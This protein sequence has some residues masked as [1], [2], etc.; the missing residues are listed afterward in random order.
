MD[1]AARLKIILDELRLRGVQKR[2]SFLDPSFPAQ[3]N[4]AIDQ[5][6]FKAIQCTRRAGKSTGEARELLETMTTTAG[7]KSLY[8]ALSLDSAKGIIWDELMNQLDEKKISNNPDKNRGIITLSNKSVIKLFGLDASYKEKRKV[9][10]Q[11]YKRVKIDEAGSITQDL[12]NICYQFIAPSLIDVN[13]TLTLLGTAENIPNTFFEKVTSGKEAG[14]SVHKWTTLDNPYMKD[15]WQAHIDDIRLNRPNFLLTSEYRTHYL[16]EWCADDTLLIIRI[17]ENTVIKP[18]EIRNPTY[19]LGVDIGF[20][21]A[22]AFTLTAYNEKSPVLYVVSASKEKELDIT[23]T[24]NRIKEFLRK[25]PIYKI[26]I[27][28]AN[29]QGVEEIKNRHHIPLIP[30]E[31]TDKASF[32]KILNDDITQGRVKY[33][34]GECNDLIDEQKTL[35]WKDFTKQDEDP[36]IPNDQNDSF[37]YAWRMARNYLWRQEKEKDDIDS[38]KYMDEYAKRLTDLRRSQND[39]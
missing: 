6:I 4:A 34:E 26:V 32:L 1:K 39:Y 14:W 7:A 9:L 24:A 20:N 38:D 8:C 36:R 2:V 5:S 35:Q 27:D 12:K 25:Y 18:V 30:A 13:G 16:N 33:F 15:K 21:D 28:G 17:N 23:G 10:G 3:Y 19:I 22:C 29:K 31:K 11:A 37:L